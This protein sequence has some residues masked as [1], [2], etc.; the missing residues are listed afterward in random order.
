MNSLARA[1]VLPEPADALRISALEGVG[2][3][4]VCE[5]KI[6]WSYLKNLKNIKKVNGVYNNQSKFL[7]LLHNE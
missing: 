2:I 6:V 1:K 3:I 5:T 7:S 4:K